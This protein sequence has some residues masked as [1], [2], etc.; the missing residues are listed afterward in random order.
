[1]FVQTDLGTG[2][3]KGRREEENSIITTEDLGAKAAAGDPQVVSVLLRV[4]LVHVQV[5]KPEVPIRRS[6]DKHL[7]TGGEGA[8][9]HSGVI[10]R[11]RPVDK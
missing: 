11:P 8:G 1:M 6:S 4:Q 7:A 3:L 9:H 5:P 2:Q 10:H